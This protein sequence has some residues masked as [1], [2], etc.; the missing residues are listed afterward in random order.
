MKIILTSPNVLSFV[1]SSLSWDA[2]ILLQGENYLAM[3]VEWGTG[4][5]YLIFVLAVIV[6]G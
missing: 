1:L 6:Y 2:V 4:L 5:L 3:P